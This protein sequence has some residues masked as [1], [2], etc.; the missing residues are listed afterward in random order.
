[1]LPLARQEL[2]LVAFDISVV[3][4]HH[5]Q[6]QR[7]TKLAFP[8]VH[9][10][11]CHLHLVPR[12]QDSLWVPSIPPLASQAVQLEGDWELYHLGGPPTVAARWH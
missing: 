7:K 5:P 3:M 8:V 6:S 1:M 10:G 12:V 4:A 2:P 9:L 11:W